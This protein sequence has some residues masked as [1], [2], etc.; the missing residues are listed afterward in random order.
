M[1]AEFLRRKRP[2]VVAETGDRLE[3][4]AFAL[5]VENGYRL[6]DRFAVLDA[7]W[8]TVAPALPLFLAGP[9]DRL[10]TV[11]DALYLFLE[12]R[13]R[14]DELLSFNKH[15]ETKAVTNGDH[16]G[17]GWRAYQAGGIHNRRQQA[18]EV[19]ISARRASKHWDLAQ[20]GTRQN[21]IAM[22]LL[23]CGYELRKDYD[24]ATAVFRAA[25]ELHRSLSI[26]GDDVANA[27]NDLARA[28]A[29]LGDLD[30][31]E[32]DLREGLAMARAAG[33]TESVALCTGN[34]AGLALKRGDWP[35]AEKLAAEALPLSEQLG[36]QELIAGDCKR[37][38]MALALQ[39]RGS[40]GLP[41]AQR[42]VDIFSRL[43]HPNL[44]G[45]LK[46]LRE[47]EE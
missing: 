4:R 27:L 1:V 20:A 22:S 31:A 44:E 14:W 35:G 43:H 12:F 17:A 7:A 26:E 45:A 24:A 6:F 39:G 41:Y 42:A 37:L 32:R 47:C 9:N 28:E 33:H 8:P 3:K 21:A 29:L 15:A 46:T 38:A 13:G 30:G 40:D 2:E 18:D 10:Q 11:C 34:L 5:I 25:L 36:R 23:G 19:L 16:Y